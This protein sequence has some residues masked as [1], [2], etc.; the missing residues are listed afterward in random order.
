MPLELSRTLPEM[1]SM[2]TLRR[3]GQFVKWITKE[4]HSRLCVQVTVVADLKGNENPLVPFEWPVGVKHMVRAASDCLQC[5]GLVVAN[6]S[7]RVTDSHLEY[8]KIY[9][10][11]PTALRMP[12]NIALR[13]FRQS[14]KHRT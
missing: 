11:D 2:L 10:S 8:S 5:D 3:L 13:I 6:L 9:M 14:Q 12:Q 1:R 7:V 4:G